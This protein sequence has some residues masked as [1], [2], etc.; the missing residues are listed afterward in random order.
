M[1]ARRGLG[2][3]LVEERLIAREQLNQA[4]RAAVRLGSP[5]VT[6]LLDQ[7]LVTEEALVEA[8]CRRLQLERFDPLQ[9]GVEQEAVRLVPLEEANRYRLLPVQLHQRSGQRV[10]R[11]AMADPLDTQAIEDIEFST[12]SIVEPLIARPSHLA[13]AIRH[14]YRGVMTKIISRSR[15]FEPA[16]SAKSPASDK[17][18]R[19]V[20]GE[21][22]DDWSLRTKP[23]SRFQQDAS[24]IQRLDALASLLIRKGLISQEEYEEQLR[25]LVHPHEEEP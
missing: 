11:V 2:V 13:E 22:L 4:E 20:F 14:H 6:V 10:L 16:N 15:S 1:V 24:I 9:T 18:G 23:V 3:I 21:G 7:G 19:Q 8:L 25:N 17:A 12:A 5:L